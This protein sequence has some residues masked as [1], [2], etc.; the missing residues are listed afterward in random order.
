MAKMTMI[1]V[2]VEVREL[3]KHAGI[4]SETYDSIIR[5]LLKQDSERK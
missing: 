3:L 4:K 2:T 5:R 1:P